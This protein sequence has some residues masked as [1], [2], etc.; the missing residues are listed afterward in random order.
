VQAAVPPNV[1]SPNLIGQMIAGR[2]RLLRQVGEGGMGS[3]YE[4]EQAL[5]SSQRAVAVKLLRPEWSH[6]P[7]VQARFHREAAT[8][9]QL[10]HFNT[11]RVYD[12]GTTDD[13]TLFIVM[14]FLHGRSLQKALD[15]L[16]AL[17]AERVSHIVSQVAASL[18]EAHRLGIVH[19]DLKPDNI[20]LVENYAAQRDVVKLVDFGI[21]KGQPG[22]DN[23]AP[24]KL[25]EFGA[26]VGTPAYM[27][28]EQFTAIGVGPRSD[29]YSLGITTYQMLTGRLPFKAETAL[30]WAQ[31]HTS[32]PPPALG[33]ESPAG[34]IPEHMQRAVL[35]ALSKDPADRQGSA[36]EFSRALSEPT[37]EAAVGGAA[38]AGS[39]GAASQGLAARDTVES[40]SVAPRLASAPAPAGGM[41]TSPMTQV[42]EFAGPAA[43][44]SGVA[45]TAPMPAV[46][47]ADAFARPDLGGAQA[48]ARGSNSRSLRRLAWGSLTLVGCAVL[49]LLFFG[50]RARNLG[51]WQLLGSGSRAEPPPIISEPAPVLK[52][53]PE[54]A[55]PT[56]DPPAPEA[57]ARAPTPARPTPRVPAARVPT[58]APPATPPV[59]KPGTPPAPNTPAPPTGSAI[60][61]VVVPAPAPPSLPAPQ[62]PWS[63]ATAGACDRCLAALQARGHYA[64]VTA[65][66]ENVLCEDAA[67]RARCEREIG[68]VAPA[69]AEQAAREGDCPAALAS[70]AAAI[71]VRVAPERFATLQSICLH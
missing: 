40:Q 3:V 4:A 38:A 61:P 18:E 25:T 65:V 12:F 43:G 70:M 31:A 66:T 41:K 8:V 28:P 57:P 13:G 1:L 68:E 53:T 67:G 33:A 17:P 10:E 16:G 54:P 29:I 64:V 6:D 47:A 2:Y 62:L 59:T 63:A 42:P 23:P 21:A 20:L 46:R 44:A 51:A 56:P 69:L 48:T 49:A 35:R 9:A 5:G 14:E 71:N 15:E 24:T 50:E 60:P 19:R 11:V 27:S 52:A 7:F 58:P 32:T 26:F 45:A 39:A 30:Q 36:A 37:A 34:P 55:A 22:V